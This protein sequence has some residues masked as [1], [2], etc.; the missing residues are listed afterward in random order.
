MSPRLRRLDFVFE[1]SPVYFV[2]ACSH[3]R[4]R[5]VAD[6]AVHE[7]VR[8]FAELGP[9]HGAWMGAYVLMPDHL[10]AFVAMDNEVL[11][12][13][14]WMKSLKN[15]VSKTWRNARITPP[16]WQ[17]GYFDHVLR[18][19]ES[20]TEKWHYVRNNPVRAGLVAHWADWPYCGEPFALEYLRD[21][22]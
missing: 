4:R 21:R 16:H 17:K 8:H 10:H 3:S 11:T 5:I 19:A 1:R 22:I 12:L 13:A 7:A 18:S 14:I 9:A 15:A 20:Y 2:T 6:A